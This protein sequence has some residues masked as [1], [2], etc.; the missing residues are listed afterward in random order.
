MLCS[1][2]GMHCGDTKGINWVDG[3][4]LGAVP[5]ADYAHDTLGPGLCLSLGPAFVHT[6]TF[7]SPLKT[8]HERTGKFL[9]IRSHRPS[10]QLM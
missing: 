9:V 3:L 6:A 10:E 2:H 8:S 4:G 7:S 1:Y 5:D